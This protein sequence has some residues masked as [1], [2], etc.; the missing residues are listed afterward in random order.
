M[1]TPIPPV[2]IWVCPDCGYWPIHGD[3]RAPSC[4]RGHG[5]KLQI[6]PA[7]A[8]THPIILPYRR[9]KSAEDDD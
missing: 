5:R 3:D 8:F 2:R 1:I 6:G 4:P 7:G 9:Y